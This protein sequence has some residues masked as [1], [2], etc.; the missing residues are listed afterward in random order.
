M[1]V[2]CFWRGTYQ[3]LRV[4]GQR[5]GVSD[6]RLP[7][8][9]SCGVFGG[10]HKWEP[11]CDCNWYASFRKYRVCDSGEV[12][13]ALSMGVNSEGVVLCKSSGE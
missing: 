4:V 11:M 10:H 12:A 3:W 5:L 13:E 8:S 1:G 2:I 9:G 7:C 6:S